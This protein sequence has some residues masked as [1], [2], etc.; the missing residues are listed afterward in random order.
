MRRRPNCHG[1]G[2]APL[3]AQTAAL[4]ASGC[5]AKFKFKLPKPECEWRTVARR[6]EARSDSG[7]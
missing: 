3:V 5:E 1:P 7:W 2:E 4:G 6:S